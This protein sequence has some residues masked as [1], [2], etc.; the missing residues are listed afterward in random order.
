[1][2]VASIVEG[3]NW[4][5]I[6]LAVMLPLP[7]AL[8]VAWPIWRSGQTVLGNL[9]G[10]GVLFGTAVVLMMREHA[11]LVRIVQACIE[12]GITCWPTPSAFTRFALYAF[13]ALAQ[14]I[15]LFT[16]SIS[17]ED[18]RRRKRFAPQWR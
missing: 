5:W 15:V 13:V 6:L 11:E 17:V 12:Q 3:L 16:I 9:A 8:L 2:I 4:P 14:V 18:N 10:T 7:I 1:V